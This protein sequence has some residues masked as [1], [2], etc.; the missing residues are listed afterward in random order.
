MNKLIFALSILVF[1]SISCEELDKYTQFTMA[2]DTEATVPATAVLDLPFDLL[3]PEMETNAESE[4]ALNNTRIDLVQGINIQEI[5]IEI[6]SPENAD[7]S[8]LKSAQV[9]M[10]AD[11]L[12][13]IEIASIDPVD[14]DPGNIILLDV[15]N[16]NLKEYIAKDKFSLRINTVTDELISQDH[17]F[18]VNTIFFVDALIL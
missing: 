8:F 4:F 6:I 11:G 13:E 17:T 9:Y 5:K 10:N 18:K 15:T 7:F 2:Y 3:T 12:A 1:T 16:N 14:D